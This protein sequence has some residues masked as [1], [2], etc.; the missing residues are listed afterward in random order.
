MFVFLKKSLRK[1]IGSTFLIGIILFNYSVAE[2]NDIKKPN[3]V[4]VLMDNFGYGEIGVY[5]GGVLRGAPTPNIDKYIFCGVTNLVS[6]FHNIH[7]IFVL[8]NVQK[9]NRNKV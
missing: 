4:L 3:I 2:D 6:L 8:H 7:L 1:I 9:T 5:G